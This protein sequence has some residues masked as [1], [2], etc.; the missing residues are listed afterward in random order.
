MTRARAFSVV[1]ARRRVLAA[2]L[3]SIR[4]NVRGLSTASN[5]SSAEAVFAHAQRQVLLWSQHTQALP[6][7]CTPTRLPFQKRLNSSDD[8]ALRAFVSK[9]TNNRSYIE[10]Q[11]FGW[12]FL[13][14]PLSV[15]PS[16]IVVHKYDE[17]H[18]G[19]ESA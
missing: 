11:S 2:Q 9:S 17:A 10:V 7:Q 3:K 18:L 15:F 4:L 19:K 12:T 6:P 5:A 14:F 8:K 16:A 1:F 13:F